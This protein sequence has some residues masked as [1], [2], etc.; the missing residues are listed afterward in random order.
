MKGLSLLYDFG[1][2]FPVNCKDLSITHKSLYFA[3]LLKLKYLL[4]FLIQ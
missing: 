2:K 1:L 3:Y 4:D